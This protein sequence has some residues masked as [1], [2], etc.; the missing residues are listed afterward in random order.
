[1]NQVP[2]PINF[3]ALLEVVGGGEQIVASLLSKFAEELTSDLAASEQAMVDH[4]AEALRQVAHRAK[5]TSA[6]LHA[7]MLSAAGRELEQACTEAD[8]SLLTIK[9]QVMSDQVSL[10][11]EALESW[12]SDS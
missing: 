6:N 2:S 10:V 8:A 4:D 3:A 9:Q 11:R 5:G 12:R 1:M 7:L